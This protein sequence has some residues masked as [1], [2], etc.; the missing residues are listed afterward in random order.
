[1][2]NTFTPAMSEK[3]APPTQDD[4][5]YPMAVCLAQSS[6]EPSVCDEAEV[7]K[8][9]STIKDHD[10]GE[11]SAEY[12]GA[13]VKFSQTKKWLLLVVFCVAEYL[14]I[15]STCG[16]FVFTD[17]IAK[18]LDIIYAQS[19]WI[20][21]SYSITFAA[22][23]LF[24]GRVSDMYSAKPVFAYGF[25]G[26]AVLNLIISF[27]ENKMAF[28]I[29]RALSGVTASATMPSSYRLILAIFEPH[30]LHKALTIFGISGAVANA[31]GMIFAG[32][33]GFITA[34]GQQAAWRW[35]FRAITIVIV[36]FAFV[37]F[38][39]V[40][41][42]SG[43]HDPRLTSRDKLKRLD[44]VG[45]FS[46]LIAIILL[47]LSLTF[48][49]SYG[50]KTAKFL[51][52]FFLTWPLAIGFFVWEAKLPDGYALLPPSFWRIPNMKLLVAFSLCINPWWTD[53]QLVLMEHFISVSHDKPVIAALRMLPSGISAIA[54][55]F[56]FP[57]LLR[58]F[59]GPRWPTAGGIFVGGCMYL[60]M[61][62]SRGA[63]ANGEY[64]RWLFPAFVVGT[65]GAM[66]AFL[67][68]NITIMTTIPPRMS[69]VAGATF[70]VALQVGAVVGL[71]IQAGLLARSPG[72]IANFSNVQTSF[73]FQFGWCV[74]DAVMLAVLFR[75]GKVPAKVEGGE[76]QTTTARE[77]AIA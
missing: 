72:G 57:Y 5:S 1:M 58:F 35:L 43:H 26:L 7:D 49:A 45:C 33:L 71:A 38:Y 14:D 64:W 12:D 54:M 31:S 41:K 61:I 69:G 40:P 8:R 20:V 17:T 67:G 50:W 18:D 48:G 22:F 19:S 55:A 25:V 4:C 32:F 66:A 13:E 24:W 51:V 59:G 36:P 39:A 62:Y 75:P 76:S 63:V 16:L 47:I 21:T 3:V 52:P 30:E 11:L 23:L 42:T 10:L 68:A 37:T 65:S 74:L 73:W 53:H 15:A 46:M 60:L 9:A 44:F 6:V 29:L 56:L 34:G 28:L 2:S 27:M 77:V 70:Q